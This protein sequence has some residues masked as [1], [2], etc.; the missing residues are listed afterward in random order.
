MLGSVLA[1]V[2]RERDRLAAWQAHIPRYRQA[3]AAQFLPLARRHAA[4]R[5]ELALALDAASGLDGFGRRERGR[6]A[7]IICTLV[8][9]MRDAAGNP[10][11][12]ELCRKY[13]AGAQVSPRRCL[14]G[15]VG[16]DVD[17]DVDLDVE[18]DSPAS[19]LAQLRET[20]TEPSSDELSS[21]DALAGGRGGADQWERAQ[22]T[23][24]AL[25]APQVAL[26]MRELF[27]KLASALHPDRER[28][29]AERLRKTALMQNLNATYAARDFLGLLELQLE[30]GPPDRLATG[31]ADSQRLPLYHMALEGQARALRLELGVLI[32]SFKVEFDISARR[33]LSPEL[34]MAS[35][36]GDIAA[37]RAEIARLERHLDCCRDTGALLRWLRAPTAIH[38]RRYI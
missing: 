21:A 18:V 8:G 25:Q 24:Q 13:Q 27:R 29:A 11:L 7:A 20:V 2:E 26:A 10:A 4:V 34:L 33:A 12:Q 30:V 16:A 14:R 15:G 28:D 38:P 1:Q 6:I 5:A 22:R 19:L 32:L 36:Q 9:D 35:L 37:A 31:D 3:H 23:T 17:V